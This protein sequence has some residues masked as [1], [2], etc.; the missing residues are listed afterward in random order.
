MTLII[1]WSQPEGI[2]MSVDYRVTDA[3]TGKPLDDAAQKILTVHWG[4]VIGATKAL[5]GYTGVA[6]IPDG[7]PD[8][9]STETWLRETLRGKSESPQA[10]IDHLVDRLNRDIARFRQPLII[11]VLVIEGSRRLM[12]HFSNLNRGP[13]GRSVVGPKFAA[14]FGEVHQP[15]GYFNGSGAVQARLRRAERRL[16]PLLGVSPRRPMNYMNLL[17]ILN[18][19]IAEKEKTVS[20]YCQVAFIPQEPSKFQPTSHTFAKPGEVVV[21]LRFGLITAGLDLDE[22]FSNMRTHWSGGGVGEMPPMDLGEL[23]QRMLRRP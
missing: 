10:S 7:T 20:P 13:H 11:H 1:G 4:P 17:S 12:G 8:G 14:F 23:N 18:R 6:V 15:V 2:Y 3:R 5:F 21:P 9:L 19:Q 16:E 22:M